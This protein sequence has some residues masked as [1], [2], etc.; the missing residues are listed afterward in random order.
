MPDAFD[1]VFGTSVADPKAPVKAASSGDAFDEVFAKA[2]AKVQEP[3][4]P[5]APPV[6]SG[7]FRLPGDR[8]KYGNPDTVS[9]EH[10]LARAGHPDPFAGHPA[11]PTP[12]GGMTPMS[13]EEYTARR[14][15]RLLGTDL[16]SES[17]RKRV[18]KALYRADADS[19]VKHIAGPNAKLPEG[20]TDEQVMK[21]I[22]EYTKA[23]SSENLSASERT[24][25]FTLALADQASRGLT[26]NKFGAK[27]A[28][29]LLYGDEEA[30]GVEQ[31]IGD[32]TKDAGVGG[33]FA[34]GLANIG[35][36]IIPFNKLAAAFGAGAAKFGA[37]LATQS[38]VATTLAMGTYSAVSED[39]DLGTRVKAFGKGAAFGA[40]AGVA[41]A[42][43]R[44]LLKDLPPLVQ[45]TVA[46][47]AGFAYAGAVTNGTLDGAALD[48]M[49][50]AALGARG[51]REFARRNNGL[52]PDG[53]FKPVSEWKKPEKAAEVPVEPAA[54]V[55][56]LNP[57]N[58]GVA[59][60]DREI[61][62]AREPLPNEPG[63]VPDARVELNPEGVGI[64]PTER[65]IGEPYVP[66]T[67][68]P[69]RAPDAFDEVF[70]SEP[71]RPEVVAPAAGQLKREDAPEAAPVV[72]EAVRPVEPAPVEPPASAR[73]EATAPEWTPR[74]APKP[75][76]PIVEKNLVEWVRAQGG[77]NEGSSG[78]AGEIEALSPKETGTTGLLNRKGTGQDLEALHRAAIHEQLVPE[79][80]TLSE[81]YDA[82]K[83][84]AVPKP[85]LSPAEAEDAKAAELGYSGQEARQREEWQAERDAS[86]AAENA[87]YD[88]APREATGNTNAAVD[89][90]RVARSLGAMEKPFRQTHQEVADAALDR[91][92]ED[93][94]APAKLVQELIDTPRIPTATDHA[95]L[96][97]H[98]VNLHKERAA[99]DAKGLR[100][101]ERGDGEAVREA[102][103]ASAAVDRE[104]DKL[105]IVATQGG[106]EWG[107]AGSF[108]QRMMKND[109]SLE[110]MRTR[111]RAAQDYEPLSAAQEADTVKLHAELEAA[112]KERDALRVKTLELEARKY[113]HDISTEVTSRK[114]PPR[115]G[116]E[117]GAK[118]KL[119]TKEAYD[120]A[121]ESF[122]AKMNR[123]STAFAALEG[124]PELIKMATFHVEAGV[125]TL[126]DF[127]HALT[128]RMNDK[129]RAMV[130]P[131]MD[132][133]YAEAR[134]QAA[135][136]TVES[137]KERIKAKVADGGEVGD[138]RN[139]VRKVLEAVI[140]SG[141]TERE[142]VIDKV[143]A[144]LSEADPRITRDRTMEEIT[145]YGKF[146]ELDN[147]PVKVRAREIRGE[148]LEQL[149][150][151]DIERK[152]RPLA[153]GAERQPPSD[154]RR[155]LIRQVNEAKKA[156][157]KEGWWVEETGPGQLKSANDAVRT[158]MQNAMK[159]MRAQMAER[160][161]T[162][163]DRKKL[164]YDE[165]TKALRV[166]Y[167]AVV[168]DFHAMF[169]KPGR[170]LTD[171]QR[172]EMAVKSTEK[173][174]AEL[175]RRIKEGDLFPTKPASK[176]PVTPELETGCARR[177]SGCSPSWRRREPSGT[178]SASSWRR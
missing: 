95:L 175:E 23:H 27:Q 99:A 17:D 104:F 103:D 78:Y 111:R 174:I 176:T 50:G 22:D 98:R 124:L 84:G 148:A 125:K 41:G 11:D 161:R 55:S 14:A 9:A 3:E 167:E 49:L 13:D 91:V 32:V 101:R 63:G 147:D 10:I 53:T 163:P 68:A 110:A 83:E 166:E 132:E 168:K 37:D 122:R 108:R 79:E 26:F 109:Y 154:A 35:G 19:I 92:A 118:N 70:P 75:M 155:D 138:M 120:A 119:V 15:K 112:V 107:R 64:R 61:V 170:N 47:G 39:G 74:P 76:K 137:V 135:D 102:S 80:M 172:A 72:P 133:L 60:A 177:A 169:G 151:R 173:S 129:E 126:A 178:L 58:I 43:F 46:E 171:A 40:V 141:V 113:V 31:G 93:A 42:N 28:A 94:S 142:A 24:Q 5:E 121:W 149:K 66:T 65:P 51:G 150:K 34:L 153:T 123:S 56:E 105:D 25:L 143:H 140:E 134:R 6:L 136:R 48:F 62:P 29:G 144:I 160:K 157:I 38:T 152:T 139:H 52:N 116:N 128:E 57:E 100:A 16:R 127:A 18:S 44:E 165:K 36:S 164:E 59:P 130:A 4:E 131:H 82:L 86:N 159:D 156:A 30:K 97:I 1:D 7:A 89:R 115:A 96:D 85:K 67:E 54:P 45:M 71:V 2:P 90:E 12:I 114:A 145:G 87:A 69:A 106:T 21:F 20:I 146:R 8:E 117:Y 77:V 73:P 162:I 33:R 158:R 81:F 88:A